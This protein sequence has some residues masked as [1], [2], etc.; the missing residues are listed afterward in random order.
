MKKYLFLMPLLLLVLIPNVNVSALSFTAT[1]GKE[2][3]VDSEEKLLDYCYYTYYKNKNKK[4]LGL[5]ETS[6]STYPYKCFVENSDKFYRYDRGST[7]ILYNTN[8][9]NTYL[10]YQFKNDF[11]YIDS[12]RLIQDAKNILYLNTNVYTDNSYSDIYFN[13]NFIIDDIE[14][15][16]GVIP[17]YTIT[18]YINN[19]IYKIFELE[20]GSSH[21]LIDYDYSSNV[22]R[23]SGWNIETVDADLNNITNN[24]VIRGTLSKNF[25][26]QIH[27]ISI[28]ILGDNIPVEFDFLY[29][30][31]DFLII[32]LVIFCVIAP[33]ILVFKVMGVI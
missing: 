9:S 3:T 19:D 1:N 13:S 11:S 12:G 7:F 27:D 16:Y 21:T 26:S 10:Y 8:S 23:F 32:L 14:S 29:I 24:I 18:Y 25:D 6:N 33:F 2:Y 30:I 15:R 4:F 5:V 20:K 31:F 17:K 22:Y 28:L